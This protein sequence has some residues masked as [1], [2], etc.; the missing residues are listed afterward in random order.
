MMSKLSQR[1][2]SAVVDLS[3]NPLQGRSKTLYE[4]YANFLRGSGG[5]TPPKKFRFLDCLWCILRAIR[6]RFLS[7]ERD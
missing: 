3:V 7:L 2:V 1:Q 4:V 6:S 5:H